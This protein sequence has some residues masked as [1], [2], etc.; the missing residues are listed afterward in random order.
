MDSSQESL[1][2]QAMSK[3]QSGIEPIDLIKDFEVITTNAYIFT[4]ITLLTAILFLRNYSK[5]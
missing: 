1:F 3:Y 2:D 5:L 4:A